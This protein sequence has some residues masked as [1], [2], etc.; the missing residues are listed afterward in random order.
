VRIQRHHVILDPNAGTGLFTW[1]ALR[2]VPEGGVW[3]LSRDPQSAE[4]LRQQAQRL[5]E[6]ERPIVLE[7]ELDALPELIQAEGAGPARFD[8]IVGRNGLMQHPEKARAARILAGLLQPG[9]AISLAEAVPRRAQ[10]LYSLVDSTP[11]GTELTQALQQAEE[12]IYANPEDP[13]VNWDLEDLRQA[14]V[15]AELDSV[16]A[17]PEQ[18]V[19]EQFITADQVGRWFSDAPRARPSYAQHLARFIPADEIPAIRALFERQLVGKACTWRS[20]VIFLLAT[21]RA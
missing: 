18:V 13:M 8:V 4:T 2:R 3:C 16:R 21:K 6:L 10:R 1:E 11:L 19:S 15:E 9:G 7:G 5:P 17:E 14:F 20:V 12:A